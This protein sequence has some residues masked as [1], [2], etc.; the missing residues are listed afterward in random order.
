M[1]NVVKSKWFLILLVSIFLIS[2]STKQVNACEIDFEI[3]EN[4]KDTYE[5]GDV[6]VVKV[7]VTLTHRSCPVSLKKTK[8]NMKGLKVVGAKDWE[9]KSTMIWERELKMKV[10]GTKDGTLTL[11]AV[12]E[13]DKDGGFGSMI[14][15][16]LPVEKE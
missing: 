12:R 2:F 9:Q 11:N 7:I 4:K 13:C 8:F 5:A 1:K 3:T 10:I 16:S 15:E 6:I 14:L